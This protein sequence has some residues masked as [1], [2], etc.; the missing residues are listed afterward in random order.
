MYGV[1]LIKQW[2]KEGALVIPEGTILHNQ[3]REMKSEDLKSNP[4]DSFCAING[5]R[6]VIGAF[7]TYPIYSSE[8]REPSPP[9]DFEAWT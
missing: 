6:Y 7:E 8:R 4:E 1:S 5:L 9:A 3:L 2:K